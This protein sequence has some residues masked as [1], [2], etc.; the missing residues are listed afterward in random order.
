MKIT[1][2]KVM[3]PALAC[4]C[5]LFCLTTS[6]GLGK[7][8]ASTGFI[9][10][11]D[12][13]YVTRVEDKGGTYS[14]RDGT[15]GDVFAILSANG[16]NYVRFRVW[17]DPPEGYCNA[18]DVLALAQRA[19]Q[20]GMG[21]MLD[22][23]YSDVWADPGAQTKPVAWESLSY[24]E[25]QQ[26]VH[27]YTYQVVHD[28][29]QQ[30]TPPGIV[31][32]G[33]EIPAGMLWDDGRVWPEEFD[34]DAQWANL[35]GLIEAGIQGVR[36]AGSSAEIMIHID[37][38]GDN[39]GARWF[40]DRLLAQEVDFD[41]IGLSYY[42]TWH[43]PIETL[44][45]NLVDLAARYGKPIVL[46]ETAYPWTLDWDDWT[47]NIIGLES[48]LLPGYPAS[49]AG[50]TAFLQAVR[51]ALEAVP[52]GLGRGFFYWEGTWIATSDHDKDG[53]PWENQALFDFQ[54]LDHIALSTFDAFTPPTYVIYIPLTLR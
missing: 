44:Q 38:G 40:F 50:Q 43:G 16:V 8:T 54:A 26:T 19:A 49:V 24:T 5:L 4:L 22:F 21:I 34:T 30:G 48:Q 29:I 39:E 53:S 10:G 15:P 41:L 35:A 47:N 9:R 46:A 11:V 52:G 13:S 51:Q 20:A 42:S 2:L 14:H 27:D 33:N 12:A 7:N 36:D 45:A 28:L 17:N 31:Q 1:H 25:L 23:H 18:A 37:K 6:T 32:I 3:L